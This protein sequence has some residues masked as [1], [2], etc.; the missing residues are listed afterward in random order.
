M[1]DLIDIHKDNL[2]DLLGVSHE[3]TFKDIQKAYRKKALKYHPDKN[4]D[5]AA[6]KVF[7]KLTQVLNLLLDVTSRANYDTVLQARA[8]AKLR[9]QKLDAKRRKLKEALETR[10]QTGSVWAERAAEQ[11]LK[12]MIKKLQAEGE[13]LVKMEEEKMRLDMDYKSSI[14][15]ADKATI[16]LKWKCPKADQ[17]N[18]GYSDAVLRNILVHYGPVGDI[19][20]SKKRNGSAIAVYDS[21]SAAK[22]C[23]QNEK[24]LK[25]C[26]LKISMVHST[27]EQ[28]ND[29]SREVKTHQVNATSQKFKSF[30]CFGSFPENSSDGISAKQD[31]DYESLT[32]MRLRQAEERRLLIEKLKNKEDEN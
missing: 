11:Q 3:S 16:K 31:R 8:A 21:I 17:T 32:M 18:G 23:I 20:I 2:Y 27:D 25:D 13:D 10:E 6:H 30:P 26:P 1:T 5:P 9:T 14:I 7:L 15:I 12:D 19:I 24:G 22:V 4:P 28:I 29:V